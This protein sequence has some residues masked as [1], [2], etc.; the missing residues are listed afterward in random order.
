MNH[1]TIRSRR[2]IIG[3]RCRWSGVI[4]SI[5]VAS[6]CFPTPAAATPIVTGI[7]RTGVAAPPSRLQRSVISDSDPF[8]RVV[9]LP[10]T[11]LFP[12]YEAAVFSGREPSFHVPTTWF[13]GADG[14]DG[15]GWIGLRLE[16]TNSLYPT[17]IGPQPDYSVIYATTFTASEAGQAFFD[18]TATADNGLAFFVNGTVSDE[19][20]MNPSILGGTQIGVA[21][22]GLNRLHAFQGHADVLAGENTLYAVVRDRYTLNPATNLGGYG[23]TGLLVASV[24]EPGTLVLGFLGGMSLLI[25]SASRRRARSGRIAR[26]VDTSAAA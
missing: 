16:T 24:P 19:L 21:Q 20:T 14:F 17:N 6:V 3:D 5:L 12:P 26:G 4:G 7:H 25:G 9:A 1:A 8:W 13:H 10:A 23:Q 11:P 18:L 2:G 22:Q 15:A